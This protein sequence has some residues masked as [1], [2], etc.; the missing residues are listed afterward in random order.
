MKYLCKTFF[1]EVIT[2]AVIGQCMN[3][4]VP[5]IALSPVAKQLM[6]ERDSWNRLQFN[7]VELSSNFETAMMTWKKFLIMKF[8]KP[9]YIPKN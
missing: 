2:H 9:Q 4:P 3:V 1:K 6:T 5:F 8:R 7:A